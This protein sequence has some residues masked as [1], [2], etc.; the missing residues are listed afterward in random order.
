MEFTAEQIAAFLQGKIVGNA[1]AAVHTFA[2]I[3]EGKEGALSFLANPH[4]EQYLYE[5]KSTIVLVN[6]G[7]Q[8]QHEVKTTLIYVD[9]A[10][11]AIAK[12]L[13]MYEQYK[14]KRTGIHPSATIEPSA[15]IGENCYVGPHAYIGKNVKIGNGCQIYANVVIEENATLGDDCL[16]YPNVSVYHAAK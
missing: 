13:S 9:D 2:K 15:T 6:K 10:Y 11:D 5:T 14:P 4:Y 1:Q 16:F 12:L 8:P 3:E 7:F